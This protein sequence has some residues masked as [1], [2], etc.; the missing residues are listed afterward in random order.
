MSEERKMSGWERE[1]QPGYQP[2]YKR[3]GR[4]SEEMLMEDKK[5]YESHRRYEF[6]VRAQ[7]RS[8]CRSC[9]AEVWWGRTPNGKAIPLSCERSRVVNGVTFAEAHFAD[10]PQSSD[11]RK[12][13]RGGS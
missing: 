6:E 11:W 1:R 9:G 3:A 8:R 10:C 7:E 12:R 5:P 4:R 13:E 2:R